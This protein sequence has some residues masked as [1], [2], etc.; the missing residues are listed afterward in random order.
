MFTWR[1]ERLIRT[2]AVLGAK[3]QLHVFGYVHGGWGQEKVE[4][5]ENGTQFVNCAL[6]TADRQGFHQPTVVDLA[7]AG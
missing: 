4:H 6:L 7:R 3:P 2:C 1:S 5:E